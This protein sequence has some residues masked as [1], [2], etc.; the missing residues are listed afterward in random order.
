M[1]TNDGGMKN[2]KKGGESR[3]K[4]VS[5]LKRKGCIMKKTMELSVLCDVKACALV[6]GPDGHL[7]TWPENRSEVMQVINMYRNYS[8]KNKKKESISA[9]GVS[10]KR[11]REIECGDDNGTEKNQRI[12][13]GVGMEGLAKDEQLE[14]VKNRIGV[15]KPQEGGSSDNYNSF[16]SAGGGK[17]NENLYLPGAIGRGGGEISLV[18]GQDFDDQN[19]NC[20][21]SYSGWQLGVIQEPFDNIVGIQIPCGGEKEDG[22]QPAP[23]NLSTFSNDDWLLDSTIC[24]LRGGGLQDFDQNYIL[25]S[26]DHTSSTPGQQLF[27]ETMYNS[28]TICDDWLLDSTICDLRGGGLQDFDQNYILWSYDHVSSTPGQQLFE[29][30]MYKSGGT[31]ITISPLW[32]AYGLCPAAC[33]PNDI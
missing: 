16:S 6:S 23:T 33:T 30:T 21:P 7:Q 13:M 26:Y 28:T 2:K 14:Q 19:Y 4:K 32:S 10:K 9:C 8:V 24:D 27:D 5:L 29:E 15:L 25:S 18:Q 22:Q 1:D 12:N 31:G 17:E 11:K 3:A 20:N